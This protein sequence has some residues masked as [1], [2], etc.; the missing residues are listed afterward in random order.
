M[1]RNG[2]A[3]A[4]DTGSKYPYEVIQELPVPL[5]PGQCLWVGFILRQVFL[6]WCLKFN[7]YSNSVMAGPKSAC[8]PEVPTKCQG[9]S[10]LEPVIMARGSDCPGLCHI[11][12]RL[13][14][15][16][17]DEKILSVRKIKRCSPIIQPIQPVRGS[18][19]PES[20]T[21]AHPTATF[22]QQWVHLCICS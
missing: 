22:H 9:V 12:W 8:L 13:P 2:Q 16:F 3:D 11:G 20:P 14:S 17:V 10:I 5:F 21:T 18:W 7:Q 19:K 1:Y 6:K 4:G 15:R